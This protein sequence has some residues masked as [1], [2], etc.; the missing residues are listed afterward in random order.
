MGYLLQ[1]VHRRPCNGLS[2]GVCAPQALRWAI[3]HQLCAG[4][5]KLDVDTQNVPEQTGKL[6]EA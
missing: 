4:A 1:F 6:A 5:K 3:S 2:A